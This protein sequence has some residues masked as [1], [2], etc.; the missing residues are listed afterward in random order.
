LQLRDAEAVISGGFAV[1]FFD[2]TVFHGADLDI[3]V[4]HGDNIKALH[5]YLTR[6]EEYRRAHT[7]R[8]PQ[9]PLENT[10]LGPDEDVAL[11]DIKSLF[12]VSK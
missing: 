2:L 4:E 3:F 8:R 11:Y 12:Q 6:Q 9:L 5:E 10:V 7:R 1:Q